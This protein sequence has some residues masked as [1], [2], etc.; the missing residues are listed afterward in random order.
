[1]K[2]KSPHDAEFL[3]KEEASA[4]DQ[5]ILERIENGY[6]PDLKK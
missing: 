5:Q 1:M 4:F 2:G 6:I 3:L